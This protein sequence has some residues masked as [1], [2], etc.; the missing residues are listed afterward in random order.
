[1]GRFTAELV[2]GAD[3]STTRALSSQAIGRELTDHVI[4]VGA[5]YKLEHAARE[6]RDPQIAAR[7]AAKRW[8]KREVKMRD[9]RD[10]PLVE[11]RQIPH[12]ERAAL[13]RLYVA[14]L[15]CLFECADLFGENQGRAAGRGVFLGNARTKREGQ[16]V[17]N[18]K[19]SQSGI[20][21]RLGVPVRKLEQMIAVLV[22]GR[23][24]RAW[25][26]PA[27]DPKT[28]EALP[29]E[30]RGDTYAYQMYELVGGLPPAIAGHLR[31]WEG[32]DR[33]RAA[34]A[35]PAR[36]ESDG[37]ELIESPTAAFDARAE[38]EAA[39]DAYRR[40][41]GHDPPPRPS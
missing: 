31:R 38:A 16:W 41:T 9:T 17:Y 27:F 33:Q 32:L 25:Q 13:V 19:K 37:A 34:L 5:G 15:C 21:A 14:L 6:R 12:A 24:L 4:E 11:L 36:A 29:P 7:A 1:M 3:S 30:L 22:H 20:A 2:T 28:G 10:R 26:P 35:S 18:P 40:V 39:A 23:V 8:P